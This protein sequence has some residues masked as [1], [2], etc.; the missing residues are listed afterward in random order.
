MYEEH[1]F[2]TICVFT[3]VDRHE[4]HLMKNSKAYKNKKNTFFQLY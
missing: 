4:V 1:F 2:N 3:Y